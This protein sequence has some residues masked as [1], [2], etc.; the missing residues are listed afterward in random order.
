MTPRRSAFVACAVCSAITALCG[1]LYVLG[2]LQ[3][4]DNRSLDLVQQL[5][6][7]IHQDTVTSDPVVIGLDEHFL[8]S[9]D[10][11]LA[12]SHLYLADTMRAIAMGQAQAA[13]FDIVLPEKRYDTIS[14]IGAGNADLHKT[15]LQ[16]I[17]LTTQT[18]PLITA[19]VWDQEH[20]RFRDIHVDYQSLL[21]QQSNAFSGHASA[22]FCPD[23]DG[24]VRRYPGQD[25]QPD[26]SSQTMSGELTAAATGLRKPWAGFIN[27][28]QGQPF[29]YLPILAVLEH[30]HHGDSDWLSTRLKG[31][32]VLVGSVL[33]DEDTHYS[34]VPMAQWLGNTQKVPGV[35]IHA[36]LVRN[37]LNEGL[38]KPLAPWTTLPL[39][40]LFSLLWLGRSVRIKLAALTTMVLLTLGIQTY[41]MAHHLWWPLAAAWLAGM[42]AVAARITSDN[43]ID[44]ADKK[45]LRQAFGGY[46]SPQV[47]KE[48][49]NGQLN[50]TQQGIT[51]HICVLFSDIRGFTTL[52]EHLPPQEVV[53]LLND[54]F[55]HM[56][57]I[58]H[59]HQGTVDKFIGDGLMAFFGAPNALERPEHNAVNAALQMVQALKTFN[60][61][62]AAK[63]LQ[64]IQIGIG[65][66]SGPAVI[67]HVGSVERHEYTAIGDTINVAARVEGLCKQAGMTIL[68]T[69]PVARG[70]THPPL[71]DLGLWP[72]KGRS[73][74]AIY[75][76]PCD[77]N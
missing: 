53:A 40:T 63:G 31:K 10:T 75:G 64:T 19:K 60:R 55:S 50:T 57:R 67:G 72:L 34:P 12:L 54:Y 39:I 6:R 76:V 68:C 49:L 28:Q 8:Q 2:V 4:W 9:I 58:V 32:V 16:G 36:Q 7:T 62:R 52:S 44:F 47:M 74:M 18:V 20:N 29:S 46:V 66:H 61:D 77:D 27:Y 42:I 71:I 33:E 65:L 59:A 70:I 48:I 56:T 17:L 21:A 35:L 45:R 23:R 26:G 5:G 37:M 73:D 1:V 15:L 51:Q 22:I 69:A 43:V 38:I 41:L 13:A 3:P 30:F 24:R 25:C 14:I 11:P